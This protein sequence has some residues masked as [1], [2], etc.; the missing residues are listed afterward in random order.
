MGSASSSESD[1]SAARGA[2]DASPEDPIARGAPATLRDGSRLRIRPWRPPDATL[3]S[4]GFYRLSA[5]SSYRRFLSASPVLTAEMR[6]ALVDVD[7]HDHEALV[8]F[9]EHTG[10]A[11]GIARYVRG[12]QTDTAEIALTVIDDWQGRGLGTL[13]LEALGARARADG[14]STFTALML[15]ENHEMRRL[16]EHFGQVRIIEEAAGTIELA[17]PIPGTRHSTGGRSVDRAGEI[18]QTA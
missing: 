9:D 10:E 6:R 1:G 14:I 3:L 11:I 7:H 16:L 15:R 2:P 5:T 17:V 12:D 8:A 4:H 18:T 13:L